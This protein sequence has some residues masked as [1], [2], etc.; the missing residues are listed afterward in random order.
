VRKGHPEVRRR[1]VE[2]AIQHAQAHRHPGGT[3]R[4]GIGHRIVEE[5]FAS[6]G[7]RRDIAVS[8]PSFAAAAAIAAQ[9]DLVVRHDTRDADAN[10]L[11][12]SRR[13]ARHSR[14]HPQAESAPELGVTL[15]DR[16]AVVAR[17]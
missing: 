12:S 5:F 4:A 9:T 3:R 10:A 17:K 15:D 6:H 2:G 14:F 1:I 7:L 11:G 13:F 16:L 8:L